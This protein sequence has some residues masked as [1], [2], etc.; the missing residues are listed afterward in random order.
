MPTFNFELDRK[1]TMW[2]RE[3]HE[4]EANTMEEAEAMMKA[5][6]FEG[7]TDATFVYQDQLDDTIVDTDDFEILN[8]ETNET[9]YS[10][11]L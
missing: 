3:Y 4:V 7:K 11:L 10:N 8:K 6:A 2:Y 9:I 1:V 5:N